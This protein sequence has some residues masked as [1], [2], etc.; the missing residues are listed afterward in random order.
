MFKK[1]N[2]KTLLVVFGVL[3][4]IV[5]ITQLFKNKQG[6]RNFET[7]LFTID[8][9]KVS[10]IT[11]VP[12]GSTDE[13]RLVKSGVTWSLQ[14]KGKT[15]KAE[16]SIPKGMLG[17]LHGIKAEQIVGTEKSEWNKFELN[18]TSTIWVRVDE[19]N[20]RTADFRVG[21]FSFRQPSTMITYIRLAND[22]KVYA[23][24]GFLAMTFGRSPDEFKAKP[25]VDGK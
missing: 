12:K 17:E 19:G 5:L 7:Q 1:L 13:I 4:A 16:Q 9:A 20:K 15:Y 24:N 10:S 14:T 2:T 18:D 6:D 23:V 8:T 25:Q 11:I 21:K 3:F 22:E